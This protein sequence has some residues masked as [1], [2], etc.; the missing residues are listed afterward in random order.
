MD[1]I[2]FSRHFR[3]Y[4]FFVSIVYFNLRLEYAQV[5][6]KTSLKICL[7]YAYLGTFKRPNFTISPTPEGY[8]LVKGITMKKILKFVPSRLLK[9]LT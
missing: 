6:H 3:P 4:M 2:S 1:D 9:L 7:K 8:K 5:F